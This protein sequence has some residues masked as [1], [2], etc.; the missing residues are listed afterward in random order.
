MLAGLAGFSG[1]G[2]RFQVFDNVEVGGARVTLVDDYGHHPTE[3]QAVLDTVRRVWPERRLVMTY[4]PHRYSRT[5]DLFDAFVAV[6]SAV[7]RLVLVDVYSAGEAPIPGADGHALCCGIR[8]R[9]GVEP[10]FAANPG[11][12]LQLLESTVVDGDVVLVQGAGNISQVSSALR[13]VDRA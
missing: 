10:L 8:R 1:V 6:L 3:V 5:R 2:R 4:Q 7:D 11:V 9:A 12:A 13:G